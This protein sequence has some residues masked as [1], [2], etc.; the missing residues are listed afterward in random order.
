M[1]KKVEV[2]NNNISIKHQIKSK[3]IN[4][5]NKNNSNSNKQFKKIM[6]N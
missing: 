2:E 3:L 6:K 1:R 4:N 5:S